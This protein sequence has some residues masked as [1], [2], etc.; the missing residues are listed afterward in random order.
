MTTDRIAY[1]RSHGY[2][3]TSAG[4]WQARL[5]FWWKDADRTLSVVRNADEYWKAVSRDSATTAPWLRLD[6]A[7]LA[8]DDHIPWNASSP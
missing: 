4:P 2:R 3:R 7:L 6:A 8:L 1:W 5:C